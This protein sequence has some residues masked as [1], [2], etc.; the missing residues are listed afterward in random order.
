MLVANRNILIAIFRRMFKYADAYTVRL[1]SVN[2]RNYPGSTSFRPEEFAEYTSTDKET[3]A[4]GVR[5]L[6]EE[7]ATFLVRF[8]D[9]KKLP[10]ISVKGGKRH[11]GLAIFGWSLG[12]VITVSFLANAPAFPQDIQAG[13]DKYLRTVVLYGESK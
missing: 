11:G 4:A 10:Q 3:Q 6:G 1:V 2:L 12:N 7:L 13:V 5:K 8:A 9:A